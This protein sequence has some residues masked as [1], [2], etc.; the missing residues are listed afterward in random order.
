M[1]EKENEAKHTLGQEE[2]ISRGR[3]YK[4]WDSDQ[5]G[6]GWKVGTVVKKPFG[7]PFMTKRDKNHVIIYGQQGKLQITLK[8]EE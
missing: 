7:F 4:R 6:D 1:K 2:V 3:R 5:E 8:S